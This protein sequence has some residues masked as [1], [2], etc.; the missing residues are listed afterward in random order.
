MDPCIYKLHDEKTGKLLGAIAIE[1]DDLFTIEHREHHQR[2]AES[3]RRR[4]SSANTSN[5]RKKKREPPSTEGGSS[6]W[7]RV[8]SKSTWRSS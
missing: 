7:L 3:C 4:I 6:S 1:V 8:N 5:S 2:M